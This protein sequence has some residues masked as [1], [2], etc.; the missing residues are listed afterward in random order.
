[1]AREQVLLGEAV[2]HLDDLGRGEPE[3]RAVAG[4]VLPPA[5]ALR[6]QL[7]ADAER[8]RDPELLR[9]AKDHVE[10]LEPLEH[11]EDRLVEALREESRL[12]VLLVLVAVAENEPAALLRRVR[13]R[14]EELRLAAGLEP[15]APGGPELDDLL[16]DVPLLVDLHRED[17]PVDARVAVLAD[18]LGE[19]LVEP[20]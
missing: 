20:T 17:A 2:N 10:L 11:D 15:E 8:R 4:R 9:S 16:D 5:D 7:G 3:L 18:G 6:G 12:D 1:Q 13:Q 14:D 19:A